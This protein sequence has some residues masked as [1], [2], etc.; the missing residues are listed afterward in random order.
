MDLSGNELRDSAILSRLSTLPELGSLLLNLTGNRRV[1][2]RTQRSLATA[3]ARSTLRTCSLRL[4]HT[5][6]SSLPA[7]PPLRGLRLCAPRIELV[8]TGLTGENAPLLERLHLN[9]TD[10]GLGDVG[11]DLLSQRL[12]VC[13]ALECLTL[14]LAGNGIGDVGARRLFRHALSRSLRVLVVDLSGN[15]LTGVGLFHLFRRSSLPRLRQFRLDLS[16]N[17]NGMTSEGVV[18]ATEHLF[19][20]V[21]GTMER[22][23]LVLR[24]LGLD[25]GAQRAIPSLLP[26]GRVARSS[27]LV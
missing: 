23:V 10:A 4:Q 25:P 12:A 24:G 21:Q 17:G 13:T 8:L 1:G 19:T 18:S 7:L 20:S 14:Q 16:R 26:P 3:L 22:V 6:L 5:G 27:V 11:C 9:L 15:N 2:V